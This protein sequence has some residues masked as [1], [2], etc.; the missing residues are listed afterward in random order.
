VL[1][2]VALSQ[3][4][5]TILWSLAAVAAVVGIMAV[6]VALAVCLLER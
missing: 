4:I 1:L 6:A 3:R 2:A 5:L